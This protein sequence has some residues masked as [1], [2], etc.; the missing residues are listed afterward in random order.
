[1][2]TAIRDHEPLMLRPPNRTATPTA[3]PTGQSAGPG[4]GRRAVLI[5]KRALAEDL[6]HRGWPRALAGLL[7]GPAPRAFSDGAW[8]VHVFNPGA[9]ARVADTGRRQRHAQAGADF[10]SR[11]SLA[12]TELGRLGYDDVV[13]VGNDCPELTV[14]DVDRAFAALSDHALVLGPDHRGGCYLIGLHPAQAAVLSE[15]PWCQN[16]DFA[17]LQAAFAPVGVAVLPVKHD[18]DDWGDLRWFGRTGHRLAAWVA[19]WLAR[20]AG[21]GEA[22]VRWFDAAGLA[23]KRRHLTSPPAG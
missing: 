15:V 17:A 7:A 23:W 12:V 13:V 3:P 14:L 1:M 4:M 20:R 2:L 11:L 10:G 8:D 22:A 19:G 16:R 18:L 9:A 6:G 5:F 21:A